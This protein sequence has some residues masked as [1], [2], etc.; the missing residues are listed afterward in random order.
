[1]SQSASAA[2]FAFKVLTSGIII[3]NSFY[4][5]FV[6]NLLGIRK[7]RNLIISIFHLCNLLFIVAT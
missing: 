6:F 3:I 4:L 5:E 7:K 1:M 2:F